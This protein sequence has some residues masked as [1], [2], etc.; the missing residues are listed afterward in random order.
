MRLAQAEKQCVK[1]LNAKNKI[2]NMSF[3]VT[4]IDDDGDRRPQCLLCMKI[5]TA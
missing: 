2:Q 3:G 1:D 5:L 4:N